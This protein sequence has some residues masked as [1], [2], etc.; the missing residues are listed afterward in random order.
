MSLFDVEADGATHLPNSTMD[1]NQALHLLYR[2]HEDL[3]IW[4][5][6]QS[7]R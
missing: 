7:W 1:S 5:E 4:D 3:T 6:A 2:F